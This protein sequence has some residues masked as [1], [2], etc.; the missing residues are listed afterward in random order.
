MKI[1]NTKSFGKAL[2]DRR[3]ALGYTQIYISEISG[4]SS[5]FISELENGK[6]TAELGKAIELASLLGLDLTLTVRGED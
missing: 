5:S 4:M 3:K 1:T 6:A 2:R